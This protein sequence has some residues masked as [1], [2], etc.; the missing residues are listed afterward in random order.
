MRAALVVALALAAAAPSTA[1]A[2]A[3]S[4]RYAAAKTVS[5]WAFRSVAERDATFRDLARFIERL[6][7]RGLPADRTLRVE[8]LEVSPA[9]RFEPWRVNA[10]DVRILT[11]TTPPSVKLAYALVERGRT[12][13]SGEE[14]VTDMNYLWNV[15]ARGSSDRLAYE[16]AML[17]DWFR[18]RIVKGRK[19][20]W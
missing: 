17:K 1:A 10:S 12:I 8:L 19:A 9:G 2:G 3:A 7:E 11:D 13:L 4:V 6:A 18:S 5:P 15:A 14:T 16:K 20:P